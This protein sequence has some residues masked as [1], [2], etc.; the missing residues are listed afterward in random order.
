MMKLYDKKIAWNET[1]K[2]TAY[3]VSIYGL[4]NADGVRNKVLR[5][6]KDSLNF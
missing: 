5:E 3:E 1:Q 6:K 4:E 2:R